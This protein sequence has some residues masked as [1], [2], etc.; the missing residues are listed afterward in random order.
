[1]PPPSLTA[2]TPRSPRTFVIFRPVRPSGPENEFEPPSRISVSVTPC[3]ARAGAA[4]ITTRAGSGRSHPDLM[5]VLLVAGS[6]SPAPSVGGL[7]PGAPRLQSPCRRSFQSTPRARR[8]RW[9]ACPP[10]AEPPHGTRDAARHEQH[11]GDQD[12]AKDHWAVVLEARE[13]VVQDREHRRAGH[14]ARDRSE[15][16]EDDHRHE[17]HRQEHVEGVGRE[18]ADD[19]GEEPA[20][21]ARI[22]RR[23]RE[24]ERLVPRH[25]DP[26]R[27]RRDRSEEHTSELQSLAYLVCRLLLEK[28]KKKNRQMNIKHM[29]CVTDPM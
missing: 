29:T 4:T 14:R 5:V 6:A 19:E 2:L 10:C 20:G 8:H 27:L 7:R 21:Y 28:K 3:S 26:A 18:E 13:G 11:R 24:R 16:A 9:V 22:E 17:V 15:A 1:M 23:D 12:R 25:V